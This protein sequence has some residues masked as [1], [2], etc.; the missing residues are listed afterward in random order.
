MN[1]G[2]VRFMRRYYYWVFIV[3]S[4]VGVFF[5][6]FF[7]AMAIFIVIIIL[8]LIGFF[9]Y[10]WYQY[11]LMKKEKNPTRI[12]APKLMKVEDVDAGAPLSRMPDIDKM[13]AEAAAGPAQVKA[14]ALSGALQPGDL[15]SSA[16]LA[17]YAARASEVSLGETK[18]AL[19]G[20]V[21]GKVLEPL[22]KGEALLYIFVTLQ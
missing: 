10:Y 20:T 22:D 9:A 18:I 7:P 13:V 3:L 19:P 17:G 5:G 21:L 6:V 4:I 11:D 16:T 1:E 12:P 14:S 8:A 15:L 2:F